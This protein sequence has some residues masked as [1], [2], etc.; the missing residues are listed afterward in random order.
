MRESWQMLKR[1]RTR[2]STRA[3]TGI[4]VSL[5]LVLCLVV[6]ASA[7]DEVEGPKSSEGDVTSKGQESGTVEDLKRKGFPVMSNPRKLVYTQTAAQSIPE[8]V[9]DLGNVVTRNL[10]HRNTDMGAGGSEI[11]LYR[12]IIPGNIKVLRLV[13]EGRKDPDTVTR[14][15]SDAMRDCVSDHDKVLQVWEVEFPKWARGERAGPFTGEG[16]EHYNQ[17]RRYEDSILE[18][19]RIH[20]VFYSASYILA[21]IGRVNTQLL[22][23]WIQKEKPWRYRCVDM[24]IWL[25][26]RYFAQL[27]SEDSIHAGKH[28]VLKQGTD[29][30]GSRVSMSKWNAIWDIHEPLL[31]ARRV[32]LSDIQTIEVLEIPMQLPIKDEQLKQRMIENFLDHCKRVGSRV[33]VRPGTERHKEGVSSGNFR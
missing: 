33:E 15:L 7:G 30:S 5:F 1:L 18:Y 32:N 23:E 4:A 9:A 25:I 19:P 16:D 14:L 27:S 10:C 29:I 20:N 12:L 24:D 28:A 3:L 21:N 17:H 26:D 31:A 8:V 22:A 2:F 11:L 13:E 6:S